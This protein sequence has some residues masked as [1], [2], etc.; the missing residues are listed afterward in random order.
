VDSTATSTA[1]PSEQTTS[2]G[3]WGLLW[4][5]AFA[6]FMIVLDTTIVTI[7]LPSIQ[8]GMRMSDS[9]RQWAVTAYT[10]AFGCLLLLGGKLADRFGHKSMLIG[11]IVGF[12]VASALGGAA[13]NMGMLVAARAI[14]GAFAAVLAPVAIS[15][16]LLSFTEPRER[17]KAFGIFTAV[18]VSGGAL[19][20]VGGGLLT[21]YL[22]WRWCLYVN[23]PIALLAGIG[24]FFLVPRRDGDRTARI[25]IGSSVV[26]GL[27]MALLVYGLGQAAAH[28]WGSASVAAPIAGAV[29]LLAVF[30]WMQTRVQHPLLPL[31]VVASRIRVGGFG[32]IALLFVGSFGMFLVLTY[33]LQSVL[34]W[35]PVKAGVAFLPMMAA[36]AVASTWLVPRLMPTVAPRLLIAPGLLLSAGGMLLLVFLTPHSS[37]AAFVLPAEILAGV[38]GGFIMTPSVNSATVG[39][40]PSDM[41]VVSALVN[42]SQQIGSTF[43]TAILNTIAASVTAAQLRAHHPILQANAHGYDAAS[44]WAAGILVFAAVL[45]AVLINT[46]PGQS[47]HH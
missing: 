9:S 14:Q 16:L 21:E 35:S 3:K 11:G 43:G 30:V 6:Q 15:L 46:R 18:L 23:L 27:G 28:S 33:Q 8:H 20:L 37:Y 36:N 7:A 22:D 13:V 5:I 4:V 29:V 12:A 10:L 25:D 24:A 17:A 34:G 31:R 39:I 47:A 42:T 38:G 32:S 19:G 40:N 26:G 2:G 45:A 44:A 41:G 1:P